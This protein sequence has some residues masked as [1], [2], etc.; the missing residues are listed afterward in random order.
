MSAD[1]GVAV[2]THD[3]GHGVPADVVADT[4]LDVRITRILGLFLRRDGVDVGGSRA[5][6]NVDPFLAGLFDHLLNQKVGALLANVRNDVVQRFLPLSGFLRV[7]I[8]DYG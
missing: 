7:L 5:V 3:H 4:D 8:I 2:G 6:G 1:I